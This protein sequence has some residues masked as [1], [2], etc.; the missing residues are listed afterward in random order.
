MRVAI[1][2]SRDWSDHEMV[3]DYIGSLEEG[4]VVVSGGAKG[5]DQFAEIYARERGLDT[6]IYYPN[7]Q[8]YG[9]KRAPIERNRVIV[10]NC[11]RLVAF[12]D[13]ESRGTANV[14]LVAR[15]A[16]KPVLVLHPSSTNLPSTPET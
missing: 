1:V 16:D 9:P 2:G 5:V 13:K 8:K 15:D 11:D 14:I 12:W 3:R 6:V 7:Y 10:H 4:D